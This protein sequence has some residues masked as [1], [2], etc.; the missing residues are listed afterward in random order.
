M[1]EGVSRAAQPRQIY[2]ARAAFF[3]SGWRAGLDGE[4]VGQCFF[5]SF[6]F[7]NFSWRDPF[8]EFTGAA[9]RHQICLTNELNINKCHKK[10]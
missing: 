4:S 2:L 6:C 10:S 7:Q 5:L 3:R 1:W 9:L 8:T